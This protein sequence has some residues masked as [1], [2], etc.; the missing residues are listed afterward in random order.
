M[1]RT[2]KD[3]ALLLGALVGIDERDSATTASNG[4]S[5]N[6]YTSFLVENGLQKKRIGVEKSFLK[7]HEGVDA[8]L[9]K[10]LD[11]M[12]QAGAEIIEV[13]LL[14]KIKEV[15]D[16]EFDVLKYEFKD[17]LNRYLATA[18]AK[19][20]SLA[21]V[22]RFNQENERVAMPF[23][24]QDILEASEALK[25]LDSKEY[26]DALKKLLAVTKSAI[27]NV[28]K[29]FSLDTIC[30]PAN[31]PSWCT[32]LVNGD[33]FT[34]YGMYSPAA[35]VGYPS[36]TIPMGTLFELPLGICFIGK[37]FGEGELL[38][39][40]YGYEQLSKNRKPPRFLPSVDMIK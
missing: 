30:G 12:K 40:G 31:G 34:G 28:F 17:G 18:H 19:A 25:G 16:A 4:K 37:A 33:F 2:V 14:S 38:T 32:D 20:K 1:A 23:F 13:D 24:K 7:V 29:E 11:Q 3:A 36:I 5:L 35:I 8:L 15:N 22:I 39:I 26:K 27:D 9:A 6:D 21:D 10:A